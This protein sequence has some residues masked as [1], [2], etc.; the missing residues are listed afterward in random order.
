MRARRVQKSVKESHWNVKKH[1]TRHLLPESDALS[2]REW[3]TLFLSLYQI[4][5]QKIIIN[6]HRNQKHG[7]NL[8]D[9]EL[10]SVG[11]LAVG[12]P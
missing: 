12:D 10:N 6:S 11:F 1:W 2:G 4:L 9:F 7:K 3:R 8:Y 5:T